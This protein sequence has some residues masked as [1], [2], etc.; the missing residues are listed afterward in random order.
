MSGADSSVSSYYEGRRVLVTGGAG[1][2][3][4]HL[5]DALLRYGA[6]RVIVVDN[7][8]LGKDDNL[9]DAMRDHSDRLRIFREDA[10]DYHTM[11]AIVAEEKPSIVFNLATKALLFSFFSPAEA[12]RVNTEIA[13]ALGELLREK[14]YERLVHF[15]SSEVYGTAQTFPMAEDHPLLAETSYAAGKAGADLLVRSYCN[16]F[17]LDAVTIRPFNNY[18]PR[19]N[20]GELAAIIP[21]TLRRI[22]AGESPVLHGDGSQTRDFIFVKD[23][24]EATLKIG[25]RDDV[26]GQTYNLGSGYETS[27]REIVETL[28]ELTGFA[29]GINHTERRKADVQ[30]HMA[31]VSMASELIGTIAHTT[32]RD[33][34]NETVQYSNK[35]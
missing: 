31:D 18:G 25:M 15:S 10:G 32:L 34:L 7:F 30:R 29:G 3:G 11:K 23:T 2:I 17:D 20:D 28:V 24:V 21:L 19:Q 6:S 9:S 4:S 35:G 1:F 33:G 22:R 14:R 27:M 5:V 8:F 13:I 16:M 26:R 12:F